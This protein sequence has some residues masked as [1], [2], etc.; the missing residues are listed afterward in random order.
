MLVIY[1][2]IVDMVAVKYII[3]G[4]CGSLLLLSEPAQQS[5][6]EKYLKVSA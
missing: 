6:K 5:G 2:I 1:S 4:M 3:S